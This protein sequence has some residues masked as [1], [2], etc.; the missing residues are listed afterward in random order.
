MKIEIPLN[1]AHRIVNHGP[2]VLVTSQFK[3]N[4]P[5]VMTV[6]WVMPVSQSPAMVAVS[7]GAKSYSH[8]L[9]HK[10]REF[11]VNV[12]PASLM[13]AVV[14]CGRLSGREIDKFKESNLSIVNSKEVTPPLIEECIGHLEC[15]VKQSIPA[16]DH[17]LFVGDVL[18]SWVEEEYFD[19]IWQLCISGGEALHH[20]GGNAF[21]VSSSILYHER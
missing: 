16:G 15:R 11:V 17:T 18:K 1:R 19:Q 6:A 21:T 8:E 2:V 9:I 10:G 4:N 14:F 3:N 13:D 7:I 20:L 12:P 5:N